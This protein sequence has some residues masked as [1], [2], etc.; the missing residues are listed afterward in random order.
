[1]KVSNEELIRMIQGGDERKKADLLENNR[2]LI[3][4]IMGEF[5]YLL[6][7]E[8]NKDDLFQA[9]CLGLVKALNRYDFRFNTLFST[10]AYRYI[11]G[12][13]VR[14][15]DAIMNA[16]ATYSDLFG[17]G[18]VDM[19]SEE[20]AEFV[21]RSMS[22]DFNPFEVEK[23]VMNREMVR[24]VLAQISPRQRQVLIFRYG[25]DMTQS[26]IGKLLGIHQ[27]DVSREEKRAK[28]QLRLI[29]GERDCGIY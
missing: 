10:F 12:E 18:E 23:E 3:Y 26:D 8:E 28:S 22:G 24:K 2:G 15:A 20:V 29:F 13:V 14:L 11:H 6:K 9:G 5:G 1:M 27:V 21:Q 17:G 16:D 4:K 19:V 25:L 7:N